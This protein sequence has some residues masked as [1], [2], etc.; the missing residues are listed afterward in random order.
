MSEEPN[1]AVVSAPE[2]PAVEP[3]FTVRTAREI[4]AL[5][6][7]EA[8]DL[9]L[10]PLVIRGAR[11]ILVADTGHGKT[12]LAFQFGH[13]VL[14]GTYALGHTGAGAGPVLVVD[15]EQGTRSI[16]RSL[17]DANLDDRADVLYLSVPD[18]LALDSDEQQRAELERVIAEH[19]PVILILDPF[20]KA[21]RGEA[22]DERPIVDLMRYLDGLRAKYGFALLLPAHPRK[23]ASSNGARKLTLHDVA[24]SGAIVRGAEVVLGLERLGHGYARLRI[25]KDRDGDL[26]VGDA[27]PLLFE[28]GSGFKLDP[29]EEQTADELEQRIL[30]DTGGWRTVKEWTKHLGIRET[31]AKEIL[32]QLV[33]AK[34]VEFMI[35][36]PGRR[37]QAHCYRNCSRLAGAPGSSGA[38]S[39]ESETA[40][41]APT[42]SNRRGAGAVG[43]AVPDGSSL[44]AVHLGDELYPILLANAV[45]D[46]HLTEAEADEQ[47]QLHKLVEAA[48]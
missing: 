1:L 3:T 25:L 28:R 2:L 33:E 30:A 44:G 13:A 24:G 8:S 20:Y 40:P 11:T 10:G 18:G 12:T 39:A 22:N 14:T 35:G 26:P 34:R 4:A 9:L 41:A 16:K 43:G 47:L 29:K 37:P 42:S 7:P 45:R 27:W 6:E 36:P 23:D 21:H 46:E 5:P 48:A 17:R 31:R 32:A 38:V 19:R 15:L